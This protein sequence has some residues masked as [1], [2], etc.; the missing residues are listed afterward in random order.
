MKSKC[1]TATTSFNKQKRDLRMWWK[2]YKTGI[3]KWEDI[4]PHYQKLIDR[5]Y[6]KNLTGE[7]K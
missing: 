5:Y 2:R 4:P 7:I 1:T 6:I 3:V